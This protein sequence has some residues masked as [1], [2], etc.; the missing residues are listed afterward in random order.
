MSVYDRFREMTL[1]YA[2][3]E[4]LKLEGQGAIAILDCRYPTFGFAE[5]GGA[6][7]TLTREG[8]SRSGK[9]VSGELFYLPSNT[10][11]TIQNEEQSSFQAIWIRFVWKGQAEEKL[12]SAG[13]EPIVDFGLF[14]FRVPQVRGWIAD[15]VEAGRELK[16]DAYFQLQS[17]L[18]SIASA[19][20]RHIGEPKIADDDFIDYVERTKRYMTDHYADAIDVEQLARQSGVSAGRFYQAFRKHTGLS[21]HKYMTAIRLNASLHM[22]AHSRAS[23]TEVAHCAG[24]TDELYFSRLFKKHMGMTP[25][26]YAACANKKI[27]MQPVFKG[28]LSVLGIMPEWVLDRGWSDDPEPYVRRMADTKPELVLTSP[29][30]GELL[31]TVAGIAPVISLQW[32]GYPWKERLLQISS[33]L[34]IASVAERW[35]AFYD[36][37]VS[38]ARQLVRRH[39]GDT[40]F[41]LAS[42][43]GSGF[44][45]YG[46][47]MNKIKDL[48][49]DDL[50]VKPPVQAER[51][52]LLEVES[53]REVAELGGEHLLLL[54]PQ[55]RSDE[56]LAGY[57]RQWRELAAGQ[58]RPRFLLIRYEEPL[59]YNASTNESLIDQT[60]NLL[61]KDT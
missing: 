19:F 57:E 43:Y 33:I 24:Y 46:M 13:D 11:C 36:Q 21:P 44:R 17:H 5:K 45:V 49:Y 50:Q 48:F 51:F 37:K 15:F 59:M 39:L 26:E 53:L 41:L 10:H 4:E 9:I 29:I 28:D 8:N 1:H 14:S 61:L 32:K 12:R 60:V 34:G 38:N 52:G 42:A 22:L 23:V 56:E 2:G 31:R 35:L 6:K 7:V 25:T 20:L 55:S 18:Y 40:P 54:M 3:T 16:P 30:P 58:A 27:V 47:R